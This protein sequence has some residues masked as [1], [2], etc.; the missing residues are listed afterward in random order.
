[1][2]GQAIPAC[3]FGE[4]QRNAAWAMTVAIDEGHPKE[5]KRWKKSIPTSHYR[6]GPHSELS[7]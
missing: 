1:V 3:A 4:E 2:V 6:M 5:S 7:W